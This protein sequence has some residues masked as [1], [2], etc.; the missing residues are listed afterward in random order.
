MRRQYND[1]ICANAAAKRAGVKKHHRPHEARA[2]LEPLGGR[3]LH[4][5]WR[6]WPGQ[7]VV[8]TPYQTESRKIFES[9]C[10]Y[11]QTSHPD[12]KFVVERTSIDECYIDVTAFSCGLVERGQEIAYGLQQHLRSEQSMRVSVGVSFNR[13]HPLSSC[14][15]GMRCLVL[16]KTDLAARLLAKL[17]L[18]YTSQSPRD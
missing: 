1:V 12:Q 2:L 15:F 3:L 8:Y 5:Y 9:L 7:R 10:F 14:A 16:T 18:L 17:C 11:L 4:A 13:Q 6:K